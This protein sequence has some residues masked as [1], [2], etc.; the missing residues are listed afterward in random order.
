MEG[1]DSVAPTENKVQGPLH[2]SVIEVPPRVLWGTNNRQTRDKS[3]FDYLK[4]NSDQRIVEA[5][6]TGENGESSA[7]AFRGFVRDA[8]ANGKYPH[9]WED[10]RYNSE[11][12]EGMLH[13]LGHEK[14]IIK[15]EDDHLLTTNYPER[16]VGFGSPRNDGQIGYLVIYDNNDGFFNKNDFIEW[17]S[18]T[19]LKEDSTL[20][21]RIYSVVVIK[22]EQKKSRLR[23]TL[24]RAKN[25]FK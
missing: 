3:V 7:Y 21:D 18:N 25:L 15:G 5:L 23:Q 14:F 8:N 10:R 24:Q 11:Y 2:F 22:P 17:A 20:R 16:A 9:D 6:D 19:P 4:E 1:V 13:E 12:I